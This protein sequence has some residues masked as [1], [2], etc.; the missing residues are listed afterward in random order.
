MKR[1]AIAVLMI[2][3]CVLFCLAGCN[4]GKFIESGKNNVNKPD[5]PDVPVDPD[6]GE[7]KYSVSVYYNNT[8]FNPGD[9]EVYA[10][11][12][13]DT[14]VK[15]A[16]L[17]SDG[18]AET[19]GLD[20]QYGVYLEGLPTKYA[21]NP[22]G[23]GATS[24]ARDTAI[25]LTDTLTPERGD[26]SGLYASNG[27]YQMSLEGTYRTVIERKDQVVY[28][29]FA[30]TGVGRYSVESWVNAYDNRI[31]PYVIRYSGTSANKFNP[32]R[33]DDGGFSYAGGYTKNFRFEYGIAEGGV[34]ATFTFA[35]GAESKDDVYPIIVDFHIK[36]EGNYSDEYSDVRIKTAEEA[37]TKA[38]EK[39][40]DEE[41]IYADLGTKVFDMSNY[42]YNEQTGFYHY[43]NAQEYAASGGFGPILCCNL[44]GSLPSYD[45][46][47]LFNAN[48]V[49]PNQTNYLRLAKWWLEEENKFI[50]Y[51]HTDFIR[52]DYARMCNS[53][54]MCYVTREL[55]EFLQ[56]FAE[57]HSLYTD[58]YGTVM[59][60]PEEKGYSANQDALWLFACGFYR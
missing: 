27:C 44:K 45:T 39:S 35:V 58:S 3:I 42:R 46:T 51:D 23:Y 40:A 36:N 1:K 48:V 55:K 9:N 8:P 60:T 52:E 57:N 34:G 2:F 37:K 10:V 30:P 4:S 5:L 28:Y 47:T 12:I 32:Q 14:Q 16:P 41:F 33:Q 24:S 49:G 6:G 56:K 19:D 17:G 38:A 54:G 26:G 11:W 18:K 13:N 20:G 29:E 50:V 22:C 43:Y 15:K 31:D 7:D 59:G 25:L 53:D 21:Y